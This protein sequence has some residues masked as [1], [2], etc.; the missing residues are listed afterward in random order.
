MSKI[1]W[2]DLETFSKVS[3]KNGNHAYAENVEVM[4]SAWAIDT[5]PVHLSDVA[6]VSR[7]VLV[8]DT[9]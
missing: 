9:F 4:L 3:I 7:P 8:P 6:C 1:L 2:L 5:A